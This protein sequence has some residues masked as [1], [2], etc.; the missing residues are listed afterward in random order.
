MGFSSAI[1]ADDQEPFVV[2]RPLELQLG[3]DESSQPLTHLCRDDIRG[4]QLA[5]GNCIVGS[6][7]LHHRLD[8]FELNQVAVLHGVYL[9][10]SSLLFM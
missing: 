4:G 3:Y 6:A 7:E 8:G 2:D 9:S 1:I 10:I 5:C